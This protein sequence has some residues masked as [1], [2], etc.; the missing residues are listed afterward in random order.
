MP[1][2][3]SQEWTALRDDIAELKQAVKEMAKAM[4]RLARLEERNANLQAALDRAFAEI[5]KYEQR[6]NAVEQQMP[7]ARRTG[8]WVDKIV[9]A[10]FGM[11]GMF[12]LKKLGLA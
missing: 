6:L 12:L 2:I 10:V 9:W 11:C 3:S 7:V 8:E 5:A 1:E 4:E